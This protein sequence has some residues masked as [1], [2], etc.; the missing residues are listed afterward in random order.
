MMRQGLLQIQSGEFQSFGKYSFQSG[1]G[2]PI[3][4]SATERKTSLAASFIPSILRKSLHRIFFGKR[5]VCNKEIPPL[6]SPVTMKPLPKRTF[7]TAMASHRKKIVFRDALTGW[8]RAEGR[9]YPWRKTRDPYAILVSESMLQQ[10]RI[11]T[12]LQRGYYSRWMETFPDW[13]TLACAD[14]AQVLKLWEGLGYYNRARNLQKAAQIVHERFAD[15]LPDDLE[16]V[17]S[18]PGVGRYTAGAIMSFAF[19]QPIP[20]VDGNVFR[21]L[22]RLSAW[23]DPVDTPP[24]IRH[25]WELAETLTCLT[26]PRLYNS[27]IMELG[28][29]VCTLASPD[30]PNCPVK[31]WCDAQKQGLI[32]EIPRKKIAPPPTRIDERVAFVLKNGKILLCPE[33]G[34]RRKGLWRMPSIS[35]AESA[36]LPELCCFEYSITRYRVT[37]TVFQP[38]AGCIVDLAANSGAKWFPFGAYADLPALGSPYRK[39]LEIA[40]NQKEDIR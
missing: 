24:A 6:F 11:A 7:C 3:T 15:N 30:C 8:F 35:E 16:T 17:L 29:R 4:V 9:D 10:T 12:V 36:D 20:I 22:S 33:N 28:Q 31:K 34:N 38:S 5:R 19:D 26:E 32:P 25:F 37:L 13:G 1:V 21:V 23:R 27:A 18:L 14:E 2:I 40:S 39:A